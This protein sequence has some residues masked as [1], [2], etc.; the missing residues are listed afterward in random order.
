MDLTTQKHI[1][2][3]EEFYI[4]AG[5][6]LPPIKTIQGPEMPEP[7]RSLLVHQNDMTPTLEQHHHCTITLN[8]LKWVDLGGAILRQVIL[9][10]DKTGKPIEF[11]AI[12]IEVPHFPPEA[13]KLILEHRKPLGGILRD[14][15]VPHY[16]QPRAYFQIEPDGIILNALELPL[17]NTP[18][19]YGRL[20]ALFDSQGRVLA[21]IVEIL[22]P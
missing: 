21:E 3:L 18:V 12:H 13:Q 15:K 5:I 1:R 8:A 2:P 11:G 22:P 4:Q 10:S 9:R 19:L 17:S 7:Q 14:L 16:G 6:T 20:N